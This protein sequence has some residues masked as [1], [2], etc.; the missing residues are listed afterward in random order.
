[1]RAFLY[2]LFGFI[3]LLGVAGRAWSRYMTW[4]SNFYTLKLLIGL[5]SHLIFVVGTFALVCHA[6]KRKERSPKIA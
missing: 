5:V 1:M 6:T 3:C 2:I 4:E